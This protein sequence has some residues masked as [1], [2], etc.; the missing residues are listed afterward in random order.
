M[1]ENYVTCRCQHCDKGIEFDANN[2]VKGQVIICP[3]CKAV[4]ALS[5]PI[6]EC[7]YCGQEFFGDVAICPIDAWPL[8]AKENPDQKIDGK[9]LTDALIHSRYFSNLR[10]CAD[11]GNKVSRNA[12]ACPKCGA[13]FRKR[14]G[15]FFYVFWGVVSLVATFIILWILL[16]IFLGVSFVGIPAFMAARQ[17]RKSVV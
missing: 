13:T 15:V 12:D 6:K 8:K 1:S 17:D 2:F 5:P 16:A 3:H 9:I 4:T 11:C 7:T 14:H 10:I